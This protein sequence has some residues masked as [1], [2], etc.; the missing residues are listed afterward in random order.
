MP[1]SAFTYRVFS[2][3]APSCAPRRLRFVYFYFSCF[4]KFL[5]FVVIEKL[6]TP[7]LDTRASPLPPPGTG[8]ELGGP[9]AAGR[10][11]GWGPG[12]RCARCSAGRQLS[13][14]DRQGVWDAHLRPL[15]LLSGSP[16]AA[17]LTLLPRLFG[18]LLLGQ[19]HP[20]GLSFLSQALTVPKGKCVT[21][22]ERRMAGCLSY[23][24]CPNPLPWTL[25]NP[26]PKFT[27]ALRSYPPPQQRKDSPGL[28]S[29]G[30]SVALRAPVL[31]RENRS[32]SPEGSMF[33]LPQQLGRG[34]YPHSLLRLLI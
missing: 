24:L 8:A 31:Y 28:T 14:R 21:Q 9:V 12:P 17:I 10:K 18:D 15:G 16:R 25:T 2:Q 32:P 22:V 34:L 1:R 23:P 19:V 26:P 7:S 13:T 6:R 5:S 29:S 20:G 11:A 27:S 4:T 3:E 30:S 33:T